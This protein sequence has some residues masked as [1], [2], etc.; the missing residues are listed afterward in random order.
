[1]KEIKIATDKLLT[2]KEMFE[3]SKDF[4]F[5]FRKIKGKQGLHAFHCGERC[6]HRGGILGDID[7]IECYECGI[8]ILNLESP[9]CNGG[10]IYEKL[11]D[12]KWIIMEKEE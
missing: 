8:R 1:M 11:K 4:G 2:R 5:E 7:Y 10:I 6:L 3:K 12:N 9:H